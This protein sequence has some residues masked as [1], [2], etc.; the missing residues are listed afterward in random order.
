MLVA[1]ENAAP[2][3]WLAWLQ[4]ERLALK[5][6]T[7]AKAT[8]AVSRRAPHV[9]ACGKAGF[10]QDVFIVGQYIPMREIWWWLQGHAIGGSV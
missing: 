4:P 10:A 5:R 9:G 7:K 6:K 3:A 1:G 8:S 2:S